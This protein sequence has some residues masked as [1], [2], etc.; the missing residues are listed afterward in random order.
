LQLYISPPCC[1]AFSPPLVTPTLFSAEII[2]NWM[3]EPPP[4]PRRFADECAPLLHVTFFRNFPFVGRV[5]TGSRYMITWPILHLSLPLLL[6]PWCSPGSVLFLPRTAREKSELPF[7]CGFFFQLKFLSGLWPVLHSR[8]PF[9]F[10]HPLHL[11]LFFAQQNSG[12]L[13]RDVP[14]C[15]RFFDEDLD[16]SPFSSFVLLEYPSF[17]IAPP[18]L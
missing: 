12:P 6:E 13:A 17:S 4:L 9:P 3:R 14:L 7:T 18:S 16:P 1:C 8:S 2:F 5:K 10:R 11:N 15:W